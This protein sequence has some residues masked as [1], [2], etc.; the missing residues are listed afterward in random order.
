[1]SSSSQNF[2]ENLQAANHHRKRRVL[3][4]GSFAI[5]ALI[6]FIWFS[7]SVLLP[8]TP[9]QNTALIRPEFSLWKSVRGG[10]MLISQ[11]ILGRVGSIG[12]F[13]KTEKNYV[14]TPSASDVSE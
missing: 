9:D 11:N 6:I 4:F 10:S 13:F 1:M 12:S 8:G 5:M 14:V 7:V 2:L 3:L